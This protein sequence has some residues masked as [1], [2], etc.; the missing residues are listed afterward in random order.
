MFKVVSFDLDNTLFSHDN[1]EHT[2]YTKV[3]DYLKSINIH[4]TF[5]D[6]NKAKTLVKHC[7]DSSFNRLLYFKQL[8]NNNSN[9][10]L[11]CYNLYWDTYI[12]A[13][14]IFNGV[15]DLLDLFKK[16]NIT[17]NIGTNF[18]LLY[19]LKKLEKLGILDYFSDIISSE[20]LACRKPS[21]L[22]M[23]HLNSDCMVGDNFIDDIQGAINN[24]MFAFHYIHV[25]DFKIY[26]NYIQ[27]GSYFQLLDF[28]NAY[29]SSLK[30][31]VSLNR[32][33]GIDNKLVQAG[34]GNISIK[35][36]ALNHSFMIIKSSGVHMAT[37]TFF[38]GHCL[39]YKIDEANYKLLWGKKPSIETCVHTQF[40]NQ[41][42]IHVHDVNHITSSLLHDVDVNYVEPGIMLSKALVKYK[43]STQDTIILKNH[44]VIYTFDDFNL[45][46]IATKINTTTVY[47]LTSKLC[48][49]TS[50]TDQFKSLYE[51]F[52]KDVLTFYPTPDIALFCEIRDT[53]TSSNEDY[54]IFEDNTLYI[55][56]NTYNK[57]QNMNEV[58]L[59]FLS[60]LENLKAND[61][62]LNECK[63]LSINQVQSLKCREDEKYRL[64]S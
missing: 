54:F 34:G 55:C 61:I 28:F 18:D 1:A 3:I 17:L 39:M 9:I 11:K 10:A 64:Q 36:K 49:K 6:I 15:K 25:A 33:V 51:H 47:S 16:Y 45:Q 59:G 62:K 12:N 13:T 56:A 26:S 27:F 41:I 19:Q 38:E 40:N 7:S 37:T 60:I 21:K 50:Y 5:D 14:T 53:F 2:A 48:I 44:G 52:G 24:K 46:T 31:Y 35:F 43:N 63:S 4:I 22:F 8:L 23:S 29:F 57:A 58:F 42:V 30:K 20:E 32:L